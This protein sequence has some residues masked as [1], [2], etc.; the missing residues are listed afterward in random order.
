MSSNVSKLKLVLSKINEAEKELSSVIST[1]GVGFGISTDLANAK[2]KSLN[3]IESLKIKGTEETLTSKKLKKLL[4][5]ELRAS[6]KT[7]TLKKMEI[8]ELADKIKNL[9]TEYKKDKSNKSAYSTGSELQSLI[10]K[11]SNNCAQKHKELAA[12]K[13]KHLES[14]SVK[15]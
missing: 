15:V 1:L 6:G 3:L 12:L 13:I 11:T 4:I 8:I 2:T 10:K 9:K 5:S 7:I 14:K